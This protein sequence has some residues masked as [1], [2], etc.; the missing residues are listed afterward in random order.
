MERPAP[1]HKEV[2]SQQEGDESAAQAV[3]TPMD[4]LQPLGR[5]SDA[6]NTCCVTAWHRRECATCGIL[7]RYHR[8]AGRLGI[9]FWRK[10]IAEHSPRRAE[11][12]NAAAPGHVRELEG[13]QSL[14]DD[15][16]SAAVTAP[17]YDDTE[18]LFVTAATRQLV[19]QL[20]V[21]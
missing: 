9:E 14:R 20:S 15:I 11:H 1:L 21:R 18:F 8:R 16:G 13:W 12:T 19:M 5:V 4:P 7:S 2:G 17:C 10:W 6:S 3:R